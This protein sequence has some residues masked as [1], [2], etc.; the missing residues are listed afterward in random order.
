[1]HGLT[2]AGSRR[3]DPEAEVDREALV[4]A[5]IGA[6][7]RVAHVVR[8][9]GRDRFF[10]NGGTE[11]ELAQGSAVHNLKD[12]EAV[13]VFETHA[14]GSGRDTR[15][16]VTGAS[17][18]SLAAVARAG[19]GR[20]QLGAVRLESGRVLASVV[21][22]YAKRVLA[23]RDEVPQGEV[24][25]AAIAQLFLRGSLFRG[26][27]K[28]T[29]A[30]LALTSLAAKLATRG[31]P[32]GVASA[33]PVLPLE[34]WVLARLGVLGVESGE[35]LALLSPDD[36]VPPV[37]PFESLSLLEREFPMRVS[38]GDAAYEV[39]YDLDRRQVLLRM[40]E[41]SRRDPPPLSYLPRFEGLRICV[42]GPRGIAVI[43]ER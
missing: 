25:R 42:E 8:T 19:L 30:R 31:H 6:D 13:V 34:D 11:I 2:D 23:V 29:K 4:R 41:G 36:L 24:A 18:V 39:D 1:V 12:V 16:L 20:D 33:A 43:R 10:S 35:D 5:A 14:L 40:T 3:A 28:T 15:V 21:R 22:V 32:A 27:L 26:T 38:V 9:R 37:L 17:A 7:P